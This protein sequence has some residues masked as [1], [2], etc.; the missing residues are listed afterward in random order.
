MTVCT[1]P[2]F[3]DY[4]TAVVIT[5]CLLSAV[6]EGCT[7]VAYLSI[8][9]L[10]LLGL[11][12]CKCVHMLLLLIIRSDHFACD[13]ILQKFYLCDGEIVTLWLVAE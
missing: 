1:Y 6:E 12:G 4:I 5:V 8:K 13:I 10:I 7:L 9:N 3:S 2:L 11:V